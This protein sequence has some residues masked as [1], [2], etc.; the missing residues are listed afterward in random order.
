VRWGY[1][2]DK[3]SL[4]Q[5]NL[6]MVYGQE[7]QLPVTYR[8]LPGF[9]SDVRTLSNLLHQMDKLDYPKLHL[10]LDRGFYSK[11]NIDHLCR[12]GQHF[13][14]YWNGWLKL[15]DIDGSRLSER[16]TPKFRKGGST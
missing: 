5:I 6:A 3:E 1:N 2:R 11:A 10:V 4:P 8:E 7:S 12:S 15:C 16:V 14:L 9:I 13:T